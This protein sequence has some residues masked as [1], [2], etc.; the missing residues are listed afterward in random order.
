MSAVGAAARNHVKFVVHALPPAVTGK[1]TSLAVLLI[2]T[3]S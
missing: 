2:T 3:V 1:G